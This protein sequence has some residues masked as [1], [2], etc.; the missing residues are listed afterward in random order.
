M[1]SGLRGERGPEGGSFLSN[2]YSLFTVDLDAGPNAEPGP[3]G[4]QGELSINQ[5]FHN[6]K[7]ALCFKFRQL[8]HSF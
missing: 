3:A 4:P 6:H 5:Y 2:N 7:T 1:F 8:E